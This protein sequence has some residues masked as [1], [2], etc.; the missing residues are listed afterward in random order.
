MAT[1]GTITFSTNDA[2]YSLKLIWSAS[3][4]SS[5]LKSTVS[6]RLQLSRTGGSGTN[7]SSYSGSIT[8]YN[9]D[10]GYVITGQSISTGSDGL[11]VGSVRTLNSGSFTVSH[12]SYSGAAP[13]IRITGSVSGSP[14][15]VS[16]S[17]SNAY[18]TL[19][20]ITRWATISSAP[21]FTDEENPTIT[22]Y[23]TPGSATTLL[24][25]AIYLDEKT[26]A[27][28]YR[29]ISMSGTSYTFELTDEERDILR[30]A[31]LDGSTT[32]NVR[33]YVKSVANGYTYTK[34]LTKTLTIINCEP[35]IHSTYYDVNA[36][37]VALTQNSEV[38]I[39]GYSDVQFQVEATPKKG[40]SITGYN[41][42]YGSKSS[43]LQQS[44]FY[45]ADA[46]EIIFTTT[47]N[48]GL[49]GTLSQPVVLVDYFPITCSITAGNIHL[50]AESG[51]TATAS[52]EIVGK[53][54][55]STFGA[56][57]VAN[58]LKIEIKHTGTN[59]EW[60]EIP[61]ILYGDNIDGNDYKATFTVNGLDYT[62]KIEFQARASDKLTN[63]PTDA[64]ALKL[65]PLFDWGEE[66]FNFNVP[67]NVNGD[68]TINGSLIIQENPVVDYI[69]EEGTEAMG[70][71]GTWHWYKYASG[72]AECYG[73]R[74]YGNMAISE[75]FGGMYS[76][77]DF[78]QDLPGIFVDAPHVMSIDV[79]GTESGFVF[80]MKQGMP[81]ADSSG[82][83][84]V[85]RPGSM[86]VKQVH[87]SFHAIGRW[88]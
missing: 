68:A 34:Y 85:C 24:Q 76:S 41:T 54:F 5:T 26:P 44:T 37:T 87:I 64:K 14:N 29:D 47:D 84:I 38:F 31:T 19:N 32:R 71:N 11:S 49:V 4:N 3:T 46:E 2:N 51:T 23:N 8:F 72:R 57:G 66:D 78:E 17:V 67:I 18:I 13:R 62:K 33:F 7:Y 63:A 36:D 60:V 45:G 58:V 42:I 65:E 80:I 56:D 82:V 50:D 52:V 83:F 70:S 88:K 55:N 53:F 59:D 74:N 48:R 6:W 73:C 39:K 25:A 30:N 28:A 1:S 12:N 86:T 10:N 77:P 75:A 81:T 9:N 35:E 69:I 79:C 22:Y 15:G 21:N 16:F 61:D 20:T 40:A 27:A 43:I